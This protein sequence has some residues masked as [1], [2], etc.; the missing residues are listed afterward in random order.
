M[1]SKGTSESEERS[2]QLIREL[3]EMSEAGAFDHISETTAKTACDVMKEFMDPVLTMAEAAKATKKTFNALY[4]KVSRSDIPTVN[5]G[6]GIRWSW[7]KKIKD[8][9]I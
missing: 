4:S 3:Y 9:I 5:L 7:V 6:K 8:K 1:T 2:K